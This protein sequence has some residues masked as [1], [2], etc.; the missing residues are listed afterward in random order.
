MPRQR[1]FNTEEVLDSIKNL[2]WEK[3]FNGTSIADLEKTVGVTRTS[4]YQ[5][6]GNK[7]Q[8]Y[9]L[10]LKKYKEEAR[11]HIMSQFD[12]NQPSWANIRNLISTSIKQSIAQNNRR[13][14]F[15]NNAC[16]ERS[17]LCDDTTAFIE[18]NRKEV[19][20]LFKNELNT[21]EQY[22]KDENLLLSDANYLFTLYSG[23]MLSVKQGGTLEEILDA[24]E[25]GLA[26]L[27]LN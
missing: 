5:A 21:D 19:I 12:T 27:K 6:F 18:K 11:Q 23:L 22:I 10:V 26:V 25:R 24:L 8:L 15:L 3:G 17:Q 4:L 7:Q 9:L 20:Q 16:S 1:E 14:C 2:F 13:G